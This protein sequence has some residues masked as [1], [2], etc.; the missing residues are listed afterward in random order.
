MKSTRRTLLGASILSFFA[1]CC[2]TACNDSHNSIEEQR[3]LSD[4]YIC[5]PVSNG[6]IGVIAYKSREGQ[7]V[8]AGYNVMGDYLSISSVKSMVLDL[9]NDELDSIGARGSFTTTYEG[10]DATDFLRSITDQNEIDIPS[11]YQDDLLFTGTISSSDHFSDAD[12][13]SSQYTFVC[14]EPTWTEIRVQ[15]KIITPKFL[16]PYLSERFKNDLEDLSPQALIELYGTHVLK[17]AYLGSRVRSLYRAVIATDKKD[18]AQSAFYGL[19]ARRKK[20]YK[21]PNIITTEPA[22]EVAK[23]HGAAIYVECCGGDQSRVPYLHLTPNEVIGDPMD[24]TEWYK[25]LNGSNYALSELHGR[26]MIPLYE[27]VAD[28]TKKE[29]IK[30][31]IQTY[32]HKNQLQEVLTTPLYQAS[33]GMHHRYFI[34]Y[35]DYSENART[36]WTLGAPLGGLYVNRQPGTLPLY[37]YTNGQNDRFS[38]EYNS[39]NLDGMTFLRTAG[40]TCESYKS[41]NMTILYEIWNGQ[42]DYAYTTED[43]QSYGDN[44]SWKKTGKEWYIKKI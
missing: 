30:Q 22:E 38:S 26:D 42:D 24:L 40:Y 6:A 28:P 15:S 23:N 25:S 12:D 17:T 20:I 21:M 37:Q 9:P 3:R 31:A 41:G 2:F 8:G 11:G 18:Y 14:E 39:E 35:K 27:L 33:N 16:I 44:G 19:E 7:F 4:S 32:I 43:K 13:Y 34:S 29:Q 5:P 36:L 10:V 1:I